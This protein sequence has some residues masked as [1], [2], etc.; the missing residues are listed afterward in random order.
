MD[1]N[2]IA[3][4]TSGP[5]HER[6]LL[7]GLGQFGEFHASS[8]KEV[9]C[10][11][12]HDVNTFLDA[13][14]RVGEED[15][16]WVRFL[17]RVIP[18]ERN[19]RFEA[20]DFAERLKESIIPFAGRMGSGSFFVRVER[21]GMQGRVHSQDVERAAADHLIGLLEARG[22]RLTTDFE[23]PDWIVVCE[24]LGAQAGVALLDREMRRRYPFVQVH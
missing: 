4:V 3:T 16:P 6:R 22:E 18:L 10:G 7:E 11:R 9:C 21:R 13:I 1:W 20:K 14:R 8:F 17:A 24:T 23:D 12:V 5:G 19:F 2:I 15:R